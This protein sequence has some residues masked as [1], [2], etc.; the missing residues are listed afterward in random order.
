MVQLPIEGLVGARFERLWRVDKTM[1]QVPGWS[2]PSVTGSP[3][4]SE[5]FSPLYRLLGFFS[6]DP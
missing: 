3:S 6:S 4:S 2:Q 5:V 1:G